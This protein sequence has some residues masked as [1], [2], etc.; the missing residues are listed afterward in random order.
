LSLFH[1]E[2]VSAAPTLKLLSNGFVGS[3]AYRVD[4]KQI[5][6]YHFFSLISLAAGYIQIC[7][8]DKQQHTVALLHVTDSA[9]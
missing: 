7:R 9:L 6:G 5:P 8:D 3:A 2:I 4:L 1:C